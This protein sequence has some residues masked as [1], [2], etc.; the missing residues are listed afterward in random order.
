MGN[1]E[2]V[3]P[4]RGAALLT[5][6]RDEIATDPYYAANFSD[7]IG[8]FV[9]WYL[10]RVLLLDQTQAKDDITHG[11]RHDDMYF[12][13]V[14]V[15]DDRRRVVI[16]QGCFWRSKRVETTILLEVLS[17]WMR[18]RN[19]PALQKDCNEKLKN[20]LETVRKAL[21]KGYRVDFEVPTTSGDLTD[22]PDDIRELFPILSKHFEDSGISATFTIVGAQVLE[23]RLQESGP[24]DR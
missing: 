20:R 1:E 22:L 14:V 18:L 21:E 2:Q 13:A 10:C 15:D 16:V 17:H 7:D 4:A 6:I 12:D 3:V 9:A 5:Q 24:R 8:R 23:I 11:N 19:L